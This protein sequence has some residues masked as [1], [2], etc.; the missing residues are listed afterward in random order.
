[1]GIGVSP[2]GSP[3]FSGRIAE[4]EA[5]RAALAAARTGKGSCIVLRGEAGVGKSRLAAELTASPKSDCRPLWGWCLPGSLT[6]LQPLREAL[7]AGGLAHIFAEAPPRIECLYLLHGNGLMI[8]SLER[9][10]TSGDSD[11][12]A[13]MVTAVTAFVGDALQS[14]L[15]SSSGEPLVMGRGRHRFVV[16]A[17]N[18]TSLVAVITGTE[19][20]GLLGDLRATLREV[21][22]A[23]GTQLTQWQGDRALGDLARPL[24]GALVESGRYDGVDLTEGDARLR[25]E[26]LLEAVTQGVGRLAARQ[27]VVLVID[28]V[29]W[30]DPSTM[31]AVHYLARNT[32]TEPVVLVLTVRPEELGEDGEAIPEV[33]Q[34]LLLMS[35]EG[36]VRNVDLGGLGV[37]ET[38]DLVRA[39][40][41]PSAPGREQLGEGVAAQVH[42]L[43][44]G[45]P[46]FVIELVA[47]L[48]DQ[49]T[50]RSVHG[51]WSLDDAGGTAA[52]PDRVHDVVVRRLDRLS[53]DERLL[54]EV[55][56][57]IGESFTP[58][59]LGEVAEVPRLKLL[60]SLNA[61]ER[62]HHLIAAS[63]EHFR[64]TQPMVQEVLYDSLTPSLRREYHQVVVTILQ[65]SFE[66]APEGM[67]ELLAVQCH[68][69]KDREVGVQATLAAAE[70]ALHDY[71]NAE[72]VRFCG[73][74]ID[75]AGGEQAYAA[76]ALRA[77][78]LRGDAAA[79]LGDY[80]TAIDAYGAMGESA[81][82]GPTECRALRK[83]AD[84]LERTGAYAEALTV[85]EH[86]LQACPGAVGADG[87]RLQIQL[88]LLLLRRGD[89]NAAEK[90][91]RDVLTA[92]LGETEAAFAHGT[93]GNV[94][95]SQGNYVAAA[96]ELQAALAVHQ[97]L[98]SAVGLASVRNDLGN[99]L[100]AQGHFDQALEQLQEAQDLY[101]RVGDLQGLAVALNNLGNVHLGRR[102]LDAAMEAHGRALAI[103]ERLGDQRGIASSLHNLGSMLQMAGQLPQAAD[104]YRRALE[105]STA[106]GDPTA[107]AR[108][109]TNLGQVLQDQGQTDEALRLFDEALRSCQD[110]GDQE[111]M[112]NAHTSIGNLLHQRGDIAGAL[113]Q[114]RL[115]L[116]LK[117][118][119]GDR[120]GAARSLNNIG[121]LLH[122]IGDLPDAADHHRRSLAIKEGARDD[123]G[124]ASSH[125]NLG[126][127]LL[128]EGH[129]QEAAEHF[130]RAH[131][132][133]EEA[134]DPVGTASALAN[135]SS[136]LLALGEAD[137]AV[138]T[139]RHALGLA[140]QAQD[141]GGQC[142]AA[143]ALVLG[144]VAVGDLAGA[145]AA[146]QGAAS[147]QLEDAESRRSMLRAE[148]ALCSGRGDHGGA[149]SRLREALALLGE[150]NQPIERAHL[151]HQLGTVTRA[152]G[153]AAQAVPLLRQAESIFDQCGCLRALAA[154]RAEL[155]QAG[156]PPAR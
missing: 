20:E 84:V 47:L 33:R 117:E 156:A 65:K 131:T 52:I 72:A 128:D 63:G 108:S 92:P 88:S 122:A 64:F 4:L 82:A 16:Q 98:G 125:N 123:K 18:D 23:L 19:S 6:P 60:R 3:P 46:L 74:C 51:R 90:A 155:T 89:L 140:V 136:A 58:E 137:E 36:L 1:M 24:L 73:M 152:G 110:A 45:N 5:V 59:L 12:L 8:C 62:D 2:Q 94:L 138:G 102:R 67:I 145:A 120:L 127:V 81:D 41:D 96:A 49:G 21:S 83:L 132:L 14:Q 130:Q 80:L 39:V 43:S 34:T 111:G 30:A 35:R 26:N 29:Q 87:V 106:L 10:V 68:R 95:R 124:A 101:E 141:R 129:E 93:L 9:M 134:G 79:A 22:R 61:L 85:V 146:L 37:G 50:L 116:A 48:R 112:A 150:E 76:A 69:A 55:A 105:L 91:I 71:A 42:R 142:S 57:V 147:L 149:G 153:S 70:K 133:C 27:P 109:R 151:L 54:L 11:V 139:A 32:R 78:E 144:L 118:R 115:S 104:H 154:T 13:G 66:D 86:G 77:Q 31:A 97:R 99:V 40:L 121:T 148:A 135:L 38:G 113:Q 28:D 126:L 25:R 17:S 100:R 15:G 56:A 103:R 119:S 107:T 143:T 114:H 7:S 75:L 44:G 53:D